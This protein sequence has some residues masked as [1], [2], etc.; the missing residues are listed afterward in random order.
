MAFR[1]K[2]LA[3]L[4]AA[5]AAKAEGDEMKAARKRIRELE[6][7]NVISAPETAEGRG[8]VAENAIFRSDRA[9]RYSSKAFAD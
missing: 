7:E 2:D 8:A 6:L 5:A 1:R 4:A 3:N 9:S